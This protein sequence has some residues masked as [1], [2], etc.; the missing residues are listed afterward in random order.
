MNS[1]NTP[2]K[3]TVFVN[4]MNQKTAYFSYVILKPRK[5][6]VKQTETFNEKK[7]KCCK[8][9]PDACNTNLQARMELHRT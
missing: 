9:E 5:I 2:V 7:Q 8:C 4:K 1:L 3:I 6:Q